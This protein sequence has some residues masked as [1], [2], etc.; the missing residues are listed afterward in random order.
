LCHPSTVVD[1]KL[2]QGLIAPKLKRAHG[3]S[4]RDES[5]LQNPVRQ[6]LGEPIA[7][8]LIPPVFFPSVA[9]RKATTPGSFILSAY[10]GVAALAA[11]VLSLGILL[12]RSA[13]S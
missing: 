11:S 1:Y 4:K 2:R 12:I 10:I 5:Y 7:A 6:G 9:S 3:Y 13:I 8:I